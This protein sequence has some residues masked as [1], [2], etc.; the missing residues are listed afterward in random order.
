MP[1]FTPL[2]P[3]AP[4]VG[5]GWGGKGLWGPGEGKGLWGQHTGRC[6]RSPDPA[7]T[8]MQMV[9]SRE[10]AADLHDNG[11]ECHLLLPPL[12]RER[13]QGAAGVLW[14]LPAAG[15]CP[16][17]SSRALRSEKP[18]GCSHRREGVNYSAEP[19]SGRGTC[20]PQARQTRGASA[21][22][23][24]QLLPRQKQP[25]TSTF[26]PQSWPRS[27]LSNW[28]HLQLQGTCHNP[29]PVSTSPAFSQHVKGVTVTA[30]TPIPA[31]QSAVQAT[32]LPVPETRWN[33][34]EH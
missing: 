26:Q 24:G 20:Q 16:C 8:V 27:L 31:Q 12:P 18:E 3:S 32:G 25:L 2:A 34:R 17:P 30:V 1:S 28:F 22:S 15:G 23:Q 13:A 33:T 4:W 10:A 29:T 7:P 14:A 21:Q 19:P 11:R 5:S 9:T 6:N